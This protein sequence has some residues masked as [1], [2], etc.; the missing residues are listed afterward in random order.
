MVNPPFEKKKVVLYPPIVTRWGPGIQYTN[1][2][3]INITP[4][5]GRK[6]IGNSGYN[7]IFITTEVVRAHLG[8]DELGHLHLGHL[9]ARFLSTFFSC[10]LA[11]LRSLASLKVTYPLQ[12]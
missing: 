8:R 10:D 12:K 11:I 4:I 5:N 3:E 1:G 9:A 6:L 2:C 7:P